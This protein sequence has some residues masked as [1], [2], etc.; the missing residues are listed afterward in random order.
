MLAKGI[1]KVL[2]AT[3]GPG[4]KRRRKASSKPLSAKEKQREAESNERFN[5][6]MSEFSRELSPKA[7]KRKALKALQLEA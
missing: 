2:S 4:P 1:K 5:K 6:F 7:Q 3:K